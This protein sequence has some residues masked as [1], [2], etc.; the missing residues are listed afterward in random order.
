MKRSFFSILIVLAA[1]S[2]EEQKGIVPPPVETAELEV[3]T[4]ELNFTDEGGSKTIGIT[5][6]TRW[7]ASAVNDRASDWL[8]IE[9]GS[10]EAGSASI[11]HH[12][13]RPQCFDYD[14]RRRSE[15]N[16]ESVSKTERRAHCHIIHV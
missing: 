16:S 10:G 11:K 9:P 14:Q 13:G 12:S 1:L 2:C 8:T 6:N 3:D 15:E 5:T 7:T 4:N